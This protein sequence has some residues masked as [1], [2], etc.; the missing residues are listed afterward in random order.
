MT[1]PGKIVLMAIFNFLL[2]FIL[3]QLIGGSALNGEIVD[4]HSF[5]WEHRVRTEVN[6]FVYYFTY[7][8][9]ISVILTQFL[10]VVT[11]AYMGRNFKFYEVEGP[12]SSK[13]EESF[14]MNH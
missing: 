7:V 4:G 11:G 8:H 6:Q 9:G 5:V 3:T 14:K 10:A 13:S 1:N 2:F 12:E